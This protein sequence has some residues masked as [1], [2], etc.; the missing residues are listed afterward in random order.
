VL[1]KRYEKPVR[2]VAGRDPFALIL[3]EPVRPVAGRDPFALILWEM[4]AYL[5]DDHTRRA[6]FEALRSRI[7]LAPA[8]VLGAPLPVLTAICR[9]GGPMQPGERAKRMKLVAAVDIDEFAG[10]L[11]QVLRWDYARAVKA[12]RKFPSVAEPGADRILMLCGSHAV[13]GLD[14]N[15]LRVLCR[16]GYGEETKNFTKTYRS[17]RDAATAELP[18]KAAATAELP[19]KAAAMAEASLLLREHGK[20]TCKYTVPRC[21][22]CPVTTSCAWYRARARTR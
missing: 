4:V 5:T 3:W 14:S 2:P 20:A 1:R 21:E 13:L 10:D 15:A 6:A 19:R 9:L 11:S 16:L 7:G 17:S 18:R 8:A 12:L 22:E